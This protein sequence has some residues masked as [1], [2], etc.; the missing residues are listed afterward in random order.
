MNEEAS[1]IDVFERAL[2]KMEQCSCKD[3]P[4]KDGCYH[5]LFAYRQSYNIGSISR[6]AAIRMLKSILSGKD[7]KTKIEKLGSIPVNSL[8]DSELERRFVEA[9][10]QMGNEKRKIGI[11]KSLIKK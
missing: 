2:Q 11:S 4:Q 9:I 1:I 3:D 10:A 5:C 6:S 8:F 7:N